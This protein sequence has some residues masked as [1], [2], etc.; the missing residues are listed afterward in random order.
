[1][2]LNSE[3]VILV[4]GIY[5]NGMDML[6]L[7]KRLEHAGYKTMR[8]SYRSLRSAPAENALDLYNL[9]EQIESPVIHFVCHSLGGLVVRHLFSLYPDQK[10][11]RVVT[12]GTPHSVSSAARELNR[13]PGGKYLLGNSMKH[14]LGGNVPAWPNNRELGSIAGSLRLGLGMLIPGI[15][16]PNDGTVA[17]EETKLAGITDHIVLPVSHFGMLLSKTVAGQIIHFL[18]YGRFKH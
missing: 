1:M 9:V 15:P 5:M 17:V 16:R 13:F 4:H 2:P 18:R 8:F 10:A 12:L 6:L 7:K 11:G 14:G 3:T